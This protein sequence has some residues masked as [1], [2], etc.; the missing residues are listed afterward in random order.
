LAVDANIERVIARLYFLQEE[1]GPKLMRSIQTQL[2]QG[3]LLPELKSL[4]PRA[5]NE[6]LMDLGRTFCQAR[7]VD[8]P[9]CP[10]ARGCKTFTESGSPLSIPVQREDKE[11]SKPLALTLLRILVY[12]KG[13]LIGHVRGERQWLAG[14]V[15]VPTFILE[16]EDADLNQYP[17]AKKAPGKAVE[18]ATFPSSITKYRITNKVVELSEAEF[19]KWAPKEIDYR[20]FSEDAKVTRF[21]TASLKSLGRYKK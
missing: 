16:S 8:C 12:G 17:R 14:Q 4:S 6:A 3:K 2:Q 13:T 18:I 9:V 7:R 21:T 19:K 5:L 11:K 10:L 15:E 1:K 20:H